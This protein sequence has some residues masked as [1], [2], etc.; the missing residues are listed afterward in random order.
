MAVEKE[1]KHIHKMMEEVLADSSVPK[2]I[3]RAIAEATERLEGDDEL[4]VKV[5][6]SIYLIESISDDL[7]MPPHA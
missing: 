1:I 5:S 3:R 6:A 2:N 7:N 4:I